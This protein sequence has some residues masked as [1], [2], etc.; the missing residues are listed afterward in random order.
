[1]FRKHYDRGDLP[2]TIRH[3]ARCVLEWKA[4]VDTIDMVHFL[5][6]FVDGI[7]EQQNPYRFVASEGAFQLLREGCPSRIFDCVDNL[8]YPLKNALDTHHSATI[9][10][11]L[12]VIQIL[13]SRSSEIAHK[14]VGHY[15]QLLPVFNIYKSRKRNIGDEIDFAQFKH[16]G[17]TMGET[18]EET[19]AIL[20]AT[21]GA[22]A[23]AQIKRLVPTYESLHVE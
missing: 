22:C 3:G 2:I 21:G 6:L 8:I 20:E 18:I 15:K 16:D 13:S 4:D 11:A 17:R 10:M 14:L 1:M 5:P 23:F 7:R 9:I 19:L 12:R